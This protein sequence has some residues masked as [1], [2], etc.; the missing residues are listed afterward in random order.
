MDKDEIKERF[1]AKTRFELK[2]AKGDTQK[3]LQLLDKL[4][5]EL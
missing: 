5:E 4:D 1:D 2:A 3:G